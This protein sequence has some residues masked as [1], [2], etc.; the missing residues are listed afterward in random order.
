MKLPVA[1]C[2]GSSILR[3]LSLF[4]SLAN[5]AASSGVNARSWIH[6]TGDVQQLTLVNRQGLTVKVVVPV[7]PDIG[8]V[9]VIVVI[10][11]VPVVPV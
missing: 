6:P 7:I 5:P 10:P 3:E 11:V 4:S 1:S 2:R 8:S 9:A